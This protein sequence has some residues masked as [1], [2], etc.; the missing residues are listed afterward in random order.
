M[1][2]QNN[3]N[4][5]EQG[6]YIFGIRPIIEAIEA[7]KTIEKVMLKKDSQGELFRQLTN[8]LSKKNIPAQWVPVE[9]LN[10]VT[11]K[12]HQGAIATI[13]TVSYAL[14]EDVVEQVIGEEKVPLVLLLDG[15]TDVRNFGA[16]VRTAECS[17]VHAVAMPAKG[18]APINADAM[19]TSAGALNIV[20][21]CKVGNLREAIFYLKSSGFTI[22][23]ATEKAEDYHFNTSYTKPTAIV[24]GSEGTG[25]SK[26]ILS[27][28][29]TAVKIPILGKI[30]SLNVSAAAAVILYEAVRQRISV[31]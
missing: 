29:D 4:E 25:I 18:A 6:G 5:V 19:K 22:I 24:L 13:S 1:E 23:A 30:E 21:V 9:R 28:C 26:S 16:I 3:T 31:C 12:N 20:P 2:Q 14:L 10:R 15:V 7:G 11:R 27:L 17:G 8:L